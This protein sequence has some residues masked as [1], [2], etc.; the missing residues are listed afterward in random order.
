MNTKECRIKRDKAHP[1]FLADQNK[2]GL[3]EKAFMPEATTF[4]QKHF[5]IVLPTGDC[6]A[7]YCG[8]DFA[9]WDE[10]D[11]MCLID[12]KVCRYEK[13]FTVMADTRKKDFFGHWEHVLDQKISDYVLFIN[14]TG[15]FL[16]DYWTLYDKIYA[17]P[18]SKQFFLQNDS[19]HTAYKAYIHLDKADFN[20]FIPEKRIKVDKQAADSLLAQLR[21]QAGV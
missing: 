7:N 3:V 12:L 2:T 14:A 11:N 20:K 5:K 15:R 1:A 4:L 21:A 10:N 6:F 9:C 16:V 17:V 18:T 8:A 19:F 13:G